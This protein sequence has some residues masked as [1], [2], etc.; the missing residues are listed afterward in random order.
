MTG[1][2]QAEKARR[3]CH[4]HTELARNAHNFEVPIIAVINCAGIGGS[5]TSFPCAT[6]GSQTKTRFS[7]RVLRRSAS[8][9]MTA[10]PRW[11]SA[12]RALAR[13]RRWPS[14]VTRFVRLKCWYADLSSKWC[15]QPPRWTKIES[16]P[17]KSQPVP[18]INCGGPSTS[19]V[20]LKPTGSQQ[21]SKCQRRCWRSPIPLKSTAR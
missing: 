1:F 18:G 16:L 11:C 19:V 8:V 12:S 10:A 15:Q 17:V 6:F 20:S 21:F 13:R 3:Y 7:R 2:P 9:P 4:R 5:S 14:P